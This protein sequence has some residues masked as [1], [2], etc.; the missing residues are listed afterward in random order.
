MYMSLKNSVILFWKEFLLRK[1][2]IETSLY[3][4]DVIAIG[5][6][7]EQLQDML[8]PFCNCILDLEYHDDFYE[9]T[10]DGGADKNTQYIC[11]LL[12][13]LTP[14]SL[15]ESWII[16][17]Y[18]QPL[19]ERTNFMLLKV[20][21]HIYYG[22]DFKVFFVVDKNR[23]CVDVK[24][25][26]SIFMDF[27]EQRAIDFAYYALRLFIGEVELESHIGD[28][29]TIFEE[30]GEEEF[31]LLSDFYEVLCDIIISEEWVE[32][33]DPTHIYSV[34]KVDEE[35]SDKLRKDMT[36]ITT[37]NT[38]L[39]E[40]LLNQEYTSCKQMRNIGGE[41]GYL[42]YEPTQKKEDIALVRQQLEKELNH[43]LYDTL[44]VAR[45]IGGALGT[46]Y[47]YIDL[48]IYDKEIFFMALEKIQEKLPFMIYYK[49]FKE[50]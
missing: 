17:A 32:Y 44:I 1:D 11:E 30:E 3:N 47:V 38:Q 50:S 33:P 12:K 4:R 31:C 24:L 49:S 18:R 7:R 25:Y 20:D 23:K 39:Q 9:V 46:R 22:K 42:Y 36:F 16:N 14:D 28:V 29:K 40:E 15:I 37:T 21:G 41:Y 45:T 27:D 34:Y 8:S 48:C 2:D 5:E 13:K 43:L 19:G 6:Y 26:Q 35:P 10:F